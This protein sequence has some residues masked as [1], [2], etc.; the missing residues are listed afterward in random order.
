MK[1]TPLTI[2]INKRLKAEAKKAARED[3]RSLT[4]LIVKLLTDYL[5]RKEVVLIWV[6]MLTAMATCASPA[7]AKNVRWNCV[8]PVVASPNG[9]SKEEFKL[10][11]IADDITG[12]AVMVGNAG[13]S[14]VDL[15]VGA[16]G[17]TFSEKLTSGAVQT[18]TITH[19]GTSVH[20]RHTIFPDKKT[21]PTQYYGHCKV[22]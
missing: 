9:L 4:S 12:K 11:F 22:Q 18:T 20:S 15:N 3:G 8:Y 1:T 16:F 13:M 19:D 10:E 7:L 14:D 6:A 2:R 5:E 21:T 17:V